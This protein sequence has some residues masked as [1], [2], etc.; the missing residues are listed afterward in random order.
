MLN[1]V[2][3]RQGTAGL[4]IEWLIDPSDKPGSGGVH[5]TI[6]RLGE[7]TQTEFS[8]FRKTPHVGTD[9]P[10]P[11]CQ[12][13]GD[14]TSDAAGTARMGR[15]AERLNIARREYWQPGPRFVDFARGIGVTD[16]S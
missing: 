10:R 16:Q 11:A 2:S 15:Q 6:V 14:P 1:L 12:S 4:G 13:A 3:S 7:A 5:A 9:Y 8:G